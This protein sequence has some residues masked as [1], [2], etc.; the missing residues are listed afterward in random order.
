M[1]KRDIQ[2]GG[3]LNIVLLASRRR[4]GHVD[5]SKGVLPAQPL[6]DLGDRAKVKGRTIFA[7]VV[8]IGEEGCD[9]GFWCRIERSRL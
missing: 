4:V 7:G 3:E 2:S 8:Q 9:G 1:G 5:I 6:T